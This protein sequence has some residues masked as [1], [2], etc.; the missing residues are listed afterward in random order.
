MFVYLHLYLQRLW[1]ALAEL[2]AVFPDGRPLDKRAYPWLLNGLVRAHFKL[3]R[4]E[5]PLFSRL[6]SFISILL[7]WWLVPLTLLLLWW[8]YLYRH[9]WWGTALHIALLILAVGFATSFQRSARATL[10]LE[11]SE[12]FGQLWKEAAIPRKHVL[13]RLAFLLR[14]V[15]TRRRLAVGF[16]MGV[17]LFSVLAIEIAI[18]RANLV[19]VDVSTKP[20]NWTGTKDKEKQQ[21]EIALVKGAQL[22]AADLRGALAVDVFLVKATLRE[23]KLQRADL[24]GANLQGAN[25]GSANLQEARLVFADLQGADLTVTNLQEAHLGYANLQGAKLGGANLQEANLIGANLQGADLMGAKALTAPQIKAARNWLLASYNGALL[26]ELGLPGDHNFR[27]ESRNFR[28]YDLTGA[29]LLGADLQEAILVN[30]NLL[31][32]DLRFANLQEA[33][34]WDANLE[35]ADLQGADL[36]DANL[37]Q[38]D[39]RSAEGLTAPQIEAAEN[40][41]FAFYSEDLLKELGLPPDHSEA[42]CTQLLK[43]GMQPGNLPGPCTPDN[44]TT[45]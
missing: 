34:L 44:D 32:A 27:F 23:A 7:A 18:L 13:A 38:A 36:S 22:D 41:Q 1:E 8:R 9:D 30:A 31:G 14:F 3:L 19:E 39:L 29:N 2:P 17:L 16:G 21:D 35:G 42:L 24:G 10:R 15:I 25:L 28:G 45:Q 12:Q 11:E 33:L 43:V 6:Q 20:P 40:W 37:Q 4:N 5:R 26:D